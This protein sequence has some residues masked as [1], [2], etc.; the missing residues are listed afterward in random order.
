MP[1]RDSEGAYVERL[2][3]LERKQY[4]ADR[5]EAERLNKGPAP[6]A[7]DDGWTEKW[8]HDFDQST[9]DWEVEA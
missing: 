9:R 5:R 3:E 2:L 8:E 6:D 4:E 1:H 7:H